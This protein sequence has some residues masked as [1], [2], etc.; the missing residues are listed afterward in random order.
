MSSPNPVGTLE[1]ADLS[2]G[3]RMQKPV[4]NSMESDVCMMSGDGMTVLNRGRP[5]PTGH[6]AA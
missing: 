4:K 3:M 6:N 2:F 1:T 5:R